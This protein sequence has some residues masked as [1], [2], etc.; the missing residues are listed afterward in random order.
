MVTIRTCILNCI[1]IQ[2]CIK[3]PLLGSSLFPVVV[4][5]YITHNVQC[6]LFMIFLHYPGNVHQTFCWE[7]QVYNL[8]CKLKQ[9]QR[10]LV[11]MNYIPIMYILHIA[12]NA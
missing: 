1:V 11:L 9:S 3:L 5:Q 2:F 4:L 10:L 8:F 12:E 7:K 6:V